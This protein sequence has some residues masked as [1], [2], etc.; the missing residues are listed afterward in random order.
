MNTDTMLTFLDALMLSNEGKD[1][2]IAI[3]NQEKRGQA[4][5]VRT[6]RLPHLMILFSRMFLK[7]SSIRI[8]E[9]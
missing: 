4:E 2:S 3:E 6:Q 8:K 9:N 7:T 1:P 5:L